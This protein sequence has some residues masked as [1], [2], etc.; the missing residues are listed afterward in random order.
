[1]GLEVRSEAVQAAETRN[2]V[3]CWNLDARRS[4]SNT[5]PPLSFH[6]QVR[7]SRE[8]CDRAHASELQPNPLGHGSGS[9][10]K[11]KLKLS[12]RA[13]HLNASTRTKAGG[14]N[15]LKRGSTELKA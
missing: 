12:R 7:R 10:C 11:I 13:A 6:F 3:L 9:G 15:C 5:L 4:A 2:P 1:M 8:G 14:W